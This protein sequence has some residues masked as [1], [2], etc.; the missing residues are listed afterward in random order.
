MSR[1]TENV[2]IRVATKPFEEIERTEIESLF[3]DEWKFF[4][5]MINHQK[6]PKRFVCIT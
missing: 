3:A 4:L 2:I 1:L 6:T 5:D